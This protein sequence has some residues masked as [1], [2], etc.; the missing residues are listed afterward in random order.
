MCCFLRNPQCRQT[1]KT[2]QRDEAIARN[3]FA[4]K[5]LFTREAG[6]GDGD[7]AATGGVAM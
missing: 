3:K 5:G 1:T 4:N 2:R 7:G 6:E